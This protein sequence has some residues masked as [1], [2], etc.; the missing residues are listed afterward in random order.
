MS[1]YSQKRTLDS[2]ALTI[3][4]AVLSGCE[5]LTSPVYL[6]E[7]FAERAVARGSQCTETRP[8][9]GSLLIE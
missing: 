5:G 3:A 4:L 9:G 6:S 7:E 2:I 1:A 8:V